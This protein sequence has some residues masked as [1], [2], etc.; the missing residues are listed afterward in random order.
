M[1]GIFGKTGVISL[2]KEKDCVSA[3]RSFSYRG[4]DHTGY[5]TEEGVFLGNN[6][7]S[8]IDCSSRANQPIFDSSGKYKIVFNGEIYNYVE[9]RNTHIPIGGR[10][11][12]KKNFQDYF[13]LKRRMLL[14]L[15]R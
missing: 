6:R 2:E 9:L 11:R 14:H 12:E 13:L 1:C 5:S 15:R 7:L 3:L 4:P 10:T 8:I